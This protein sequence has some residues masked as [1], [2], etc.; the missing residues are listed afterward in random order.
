LAFERLDDV[1]AEQVSAALEQALGAIF[2][3]DGIKR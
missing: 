3:N 2:R 1:E